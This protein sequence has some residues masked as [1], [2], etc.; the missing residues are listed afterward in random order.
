MFTHP[1]ED[2]VVTIREAA[3]LQSFNDSFKFVGRYHSQCRQVGNAVAP[4][5]AV[6][7]ALSISKLLGKVRGDQDSGST[8][9]MPDRVKNS[10]VSSK[11]ARLQLI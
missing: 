8:R 10:I 4:Q 1:I 7:V 11:P 5:V 2:R 3:R 9:T 6:N